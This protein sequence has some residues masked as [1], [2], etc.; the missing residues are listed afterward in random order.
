MKRGLV[1]LTACHCGAQNSR[2]PLRTQKGQVWIADGP[3]EGWTIITR[4]GERAG[5]L[6]IA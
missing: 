5:R 3:R 6:R 4:E 1:V 2:R